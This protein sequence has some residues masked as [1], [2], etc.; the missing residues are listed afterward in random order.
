MVRALLKNTD[1]ECSSSSHTPYTHYNNNN[2]SIR[3]THTPDFHAITDQY[4]SDPLEFFDTRN[5]NLFSV[6]QGVRGDEEPTA[7]GS[8][9]CDGR[10][11]VAGRAA[12]DGLV[13]NAVSVCCTRPLSHGLTITNHLFLVLAGRFIR[14]SF[15]C[16]GNRVHSRNWIESVWRQVRGTTQEFR[17]RMAWG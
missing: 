5:F 2:D 12:L 6:L 10:G 4:R 7:G 17:R 3:L 13:Q 11:T 15:Q 9:P 14:A 16:M 8:G 1:T